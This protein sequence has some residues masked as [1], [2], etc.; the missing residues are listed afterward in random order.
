ME[1]TNRRVGAAGRLPMWLIALGV[2]GWLTASSLAGP[3][4]G[5]YVFGDS[6]S[7]VGNLTDATFGLF[8]GPTYFNGRVSNGPVFVEHLSIALGLGTSTASRSGGSNFAFGGA[9]T[10]GTFFVQD[11]NEQVTDFLNNR[12][13]DPNALYMVFAGAND[14]VGGQTDLNAPVNQLATDIGRLYDDGARQFFVPNLPR[15]G[16]TPQYNGDAEQAAIINARSELFNELLAEMLHGLPSTRTEIQIYQ[17]DIE[18]RF[19]EIVADAAYFGFA[20]VTDP[21]A[22]G[23]EPGDGNYDEEQIVSAP[24]SYLFWDDLHPTATGHALLAA[25]AL[26]A[27]LPAGDYNRDWVVD[28]ADYTV[29]RDTLGSSTQLAAD[30]DRSRAVDEGDYAIW[31]ANFGASSYAMNGVLNNPILV[32]EPTAV[33]ASFLTALG[34]LMLYASTVRNRPPA[35]DGPGVA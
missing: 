20:N 1:L 21:A 11:V 18:A 30:G 26:R 9:R 23:L 16:L 27:L 6:L 5:L 28:I 34:A 31:T 8:P 3:F 24:N 32:P 35:L 33:V 19:N 13:A 25:E 22:P 17:F 4:S 29:W 7:D 15:L 14:L 12:T 2:H 10:S